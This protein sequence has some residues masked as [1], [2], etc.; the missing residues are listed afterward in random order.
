[1]VATCVM[2]KVS[3]YCTCCRGSSLVSGVSGSFSGELWRSG[4]PLW[5]EWNDA[6]VSAEKWDASRGAK[7]AKARKSPLSV[8]V[9]SVLEMI[10]L[11]VYGGVVIR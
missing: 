11:S 7:D 8:S 1:M 6:E 5:P 2:C 4:A 9:K 3:T 10:C